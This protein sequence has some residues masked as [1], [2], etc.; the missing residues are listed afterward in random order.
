MLEFLS[1]WIAPLWARMLAPFRTVPVTVDSLS[2]E[3][4]ARRVD[5][6][7]KCDVSPGSVPTTVWARLKRSLGFAADPHEQT[8][9]I[10]IVR[11]QQRETCVAKQLPYTRGKPTPATNRKIRYP[12]SWKPTCKMV[13]DLEKSFAEGDAAEDRGESAGSA[14]MHEASSTV[15]ASS[16]LISKGTRIRRTDEVAAGKATAALQDSGPLLGEDKGNEM[17]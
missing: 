8:R 3:L 5:K 1:A 16:H 9:Q 13:A 4:S 17:V 2:H 15:V 12:E 14:G 11:Q 6:N 10:E 7:D